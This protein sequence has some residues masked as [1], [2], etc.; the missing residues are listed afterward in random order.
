MI[1]PITYMVMS[2]VAYYLGS[3]VGEYGHTR[4]KYYIAVVS[5]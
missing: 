5:I 4:Y 1:G 3:K 2:P